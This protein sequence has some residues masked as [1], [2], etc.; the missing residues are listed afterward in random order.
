MKKDANIPSGDDIADYSRSQKKPFAAICDTL[1]LEIDKALSDATSKIYYSMPVWFMD[2]NPVV[3]YNATSNHVNLL[4]WSG[5]SFGEPGLAAA[6][7]FKA[8]QIKYRSVEDI[9]VKALRRWLRKSK[10]FIWDYQ[11]LRKNA[12]NLVMIQR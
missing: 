1:R 6:G 5:Q 9:D 12:G 3:G 10:K 8:A 7:K 2:G 4:F 11:N